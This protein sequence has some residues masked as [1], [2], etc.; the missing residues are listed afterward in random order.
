MVCAEGLRVWRSFKNCANQFGNDSGVGS[1]F[2]W[3]TSSDCFYTLNADRKKMDNHSYPSNTGKMLRD[4]AFLR[5]WGR[6]EVSP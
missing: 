1:G 2:S 6:G 3:K 4:H 5:Y